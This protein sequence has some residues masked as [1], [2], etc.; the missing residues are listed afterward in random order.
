MNLEHNG[1]TIISW[2][3]NSSK[4]VLTEEGGIPQLKERL[5]AAA[6]CQKNGYW[7]GFHFDPII[8][9]PGWEEDY[10][11]TIKMLFSYIKPQ[12]IAWIS[13]G[14]FRY[15]PPLKDIIKVKFPK[16][17]IIYGE[18]VPGLD[19]KK[20]YFKPIRI[21]IYKKMLSWLRN[22]AANAPVY[23]CMELADVWKKVFGFVPDKGG[24]K[25]ML[26]RTLL[27]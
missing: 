20:R 14:T 6:K 17:K 21:H 8:Y 4:V 25:Q 22:Y 18:F 15:M 12:G 11:N 26:D 1:H 19:G 27:R 2:S 5:E 24:L 3:L 10:K 16:T 13:L 23:L 7:L 9:Y